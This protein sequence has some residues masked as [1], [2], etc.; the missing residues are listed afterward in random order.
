MVRTRTTRSKK[1]KNCSGSSLHRL[2]GTQDAETQHTKR[3]TRVVK[4]RRD[5]DRFDNTDNRQGDFTTA[6]ASKTPA[7]VDEKRN[8][9]NGN[10]SAE[11][12]QSP[13]SSSSC[14]VALQQKKVRK[15]HKMTF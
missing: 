8:I 7:V 11:L 10:I 14:V 9:E 15:Q 6:T 5:K 12:S 13:S 4:A 1:G 3:T 2:N